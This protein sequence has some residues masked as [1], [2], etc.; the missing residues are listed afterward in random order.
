MARVIVLG[1]LNM[2]LIVETSRRPAVGETVVGSGFRTLPGGKGLNQAVAAARAGVGTVMIGRVGNDDFGRILLDLLDREGIDASRV[3]TD[4][5]AATGIAL[6]TVC[7]G[8]NTIVV[9]SGANMTL[10]VDAADDLEIAHDDVCVAQME[11]PTATAEAFFVRARGVGARTVL[12]AAPALPVPA[13]LLASTGTLIVNEAELAALANAAVSDS[14]PI[15]H[16]AAVANALVAVDR[17][18][19]VTLGRRGVVGLVHGGAPLVV[20]GHRA[21]AIDSTGAGDCFVGNF[22]ARMALGDRPGEAQRY[23]N[24]AAAVAVTRRG[25]APSMPTASEVRRLFGQ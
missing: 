20:D 17:R 3:G 2:D 21:D 16:I 7:A 23:A 14:D 22:A 19:I 15:E 10:P 25:A 9:A 6:I 18:V 11:T 24:A 13:A 4:Q 5:R 1:S 8:D 12:N